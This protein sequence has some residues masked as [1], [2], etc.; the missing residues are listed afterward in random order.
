MTASQM[1]ASQFEGINQDLPRRALE[2]F[3]ERTTFYAESVS[4]W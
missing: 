2:E 1:L 3:I 4:L